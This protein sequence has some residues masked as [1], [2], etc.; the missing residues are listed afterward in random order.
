MIP[1]YKYGFLLGPDGRI[2]DFINK[3]VPSEYNVFWLLM[4]LVLFFFIVG[5]EDKKKHGLAA[6]IKFF[7]IAGFLINFV[8][9]IRPDFVI[10]GCVFGVTLHLALNFKYMRRVN[11]MISFLML[12]IL[13]GFLFGNSLILGISALI[14]V[15]LGFVFS[16]GHGAQMFGSPKEIEIMKQEGFD[17][18]DP[19]RVAQKYIQLIKDAEARSRSVVGGTPLERQIVNDTRTATMSLGKFELDQVSAQIHQE[20]MI[21][22]AQAIARTESGMLEGEMKLEQREQ[23]INRNIDSIVNRIMRMAQ[24]LLNSNN[25]SELMTRMKVVL[26]QGLKQLLSMFYNLVQNQKFM[27]KYREKGLEQLDRAD[28]VIAQ[29]AKETRKIEQDASHVVKQLKRVGLKNLGM[30]KKEVRRRL[31][32]VFKNSFKFIFWFVVMCIGFILKLVG[33]LNLI[34]KSISGLL[35]RIGRVFFFP[36]V[37]IITVVVAVVLMIFLDLVIGLLVLGLFLLIPIGMVLRYL[38]IPFKIIGNA[39]SIMFKKARPKLPE[40]TRLIAQFSKEYALMRIELVKINMMKRALNSTVKKLLKLLNWITTKTKE[41]IQIEKESDSLRKLVVAN[42]KKYRADITQLN[43]GVF[44]FKRYYDWVNS[45]TNLTLPQNVMAETNGYINIIFFKIGDIC[46]IAIEENKSLIFPFIKNTGKI[47]QDAWGIESAKKY[48]D[49]VSAKLQDSFVKLDEACV[50]VAG[51]GAAQNIIPLMNVMAKEGEINSKYAL[52]KNKGIENH[53]TR[54]HKDMVAAAK[55]TEEQTQLLERERSEL[56]SRRLA[57]LKSIHYVSDVLSK[58]ETKIHK[59]FEKGM[60]K[61]MGGIK[62]AFD[63]LKKGQKTAEGM[64]K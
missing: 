3:L 42:E 46:N 32:N 45:Q 29:S 35:V 27:E 48:C 33:F 58:S 36:V 18:N 54:A 2:M 13:S 62:N 43:Q 34:F 60:G 22:S 44:A 25:R 4:I 30:V 17:S 49:R 50:A 28:Q 11:V 1:V 26:T 9:P 57:V 52:R 55:K 14:F 56:N 64:A 7:V 51:G 31:M 47:L 38:G 23:I 39:G 40:L 10:Y 16:K 6:A 53:F 59:K 8:F 21:A 19:V 63:S 15:T 20:A 61:A 12:W 24:S 37:A 41:I 5:V